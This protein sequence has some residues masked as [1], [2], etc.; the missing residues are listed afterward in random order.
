MRT[1]AA[2]LTSR[3]GRSM[4]PKPVKTGAQGS[5][6]GQGFLTR[7]RREKPLAVVLGI[8]LLLLILVALFADVLA[9]FV[10]LRAPGRGW[11]QDR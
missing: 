4:T 10:A 1:F 8:V 6:A 9:P 2:F 11:L 5:P 7:L 3:R